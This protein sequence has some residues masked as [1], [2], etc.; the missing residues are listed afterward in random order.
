[1]TVQTA[2]CNVKYSLLQFHFLFLAKFN[3][4]FKTQ[5]V[6]GFVLFERIRLFVTSVS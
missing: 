6:Y 3:V 5:L 4:M 1:M 2:M